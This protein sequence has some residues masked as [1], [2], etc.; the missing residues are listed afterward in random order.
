M[1]SQRTLVKHPWNQKTMEKSQN[2]SSK[3]GNI[4][5]GKGRETIYM[6]KVGGRQK[7]RNDFWS[8]DIPGP[9]LR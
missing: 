2:P 5:E 4:G 6:Y 9:L 1:K 8:S 7:E 3:A